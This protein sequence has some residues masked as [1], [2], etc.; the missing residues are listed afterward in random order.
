VGGNIAI[1]EG[2]L[3]ASEGRINLV[4]VASPSE[5]L[6]DLPGK[7]EITHTDLSDKLGTISVFGGANINIQNEGEGI[8]IKGGV[9]KIEEGS[10]I[11]SQNSVSGKGAPISVIADEVELINNAIIE[12]INVDF[13]NKA[14]GGNILISANHINIEH[15]GVAGSYNIGSGM[16]GDLIIKAN[17]KV[18]ISGNTYTGLINVC[19]FDGC[20]P[21]TISIKAADLIIDGSRAIVGG[22]GSFSGAS[23]D[24]IIEVK[25][26]S[27]ESG[28]QISASTLGS[29]PGGDIFINV[30]ES[31]KIDEGVIKAD[32][33][34]FTDIA[35][36]GGDITICAKNILIKGEEYLKGG[37]IASDTAGKG[38]AGDITITAQNSFRIAGYGYVTAISMRDPIDQNRSDVGDAGKISISVPE[39]I[40]D[41]N[42]AIR[43][44]T[45]T[46][47]IKQKPWKCDML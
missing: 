40:M 44:S 37:G 34:N 42:A 22:V 11:S 26:L 27:L 17:G 28:S 46:G 19:S 47:R 38:N 31:L 32:N 39:L 24:I 41:G 8:F 20:K 43:T 4:S 6:H 21:G 2:K 7:V 15:G 23:A 18:T 35:S 13:F 12:S 30:E 45:E 25:N 14:Q 33:F 29:S 5:V 36:K 1:A 9:F 16:G 3:S 10:Q